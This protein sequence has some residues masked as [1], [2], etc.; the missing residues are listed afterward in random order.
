VRSTRTDVKTGPR[1]SE[2]AGKPDVLGAFKRA[3][4]HRQYLW[5][6]GRRN[7]VLRPM[8]DSHFISREQ[9][10]AAQATSLKLAPPNAEANGAPYFMDLVR[11]QLVPQYTESE[12]NNTAMRVY[13]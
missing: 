2:E 1:P 9:L 7:V 6:I 5:V 4:V 11:D 13:T 12:L 8:F 10:A 3:S